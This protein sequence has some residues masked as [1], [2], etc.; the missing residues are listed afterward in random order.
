ML[1]NL[2]SFDLDASDLAWA[3]EHTLIVKKWN[4]D[5]SKSHA[6]QRYALELVQEN[7]I[8]I[9]ICCSHPH[10]LTNGRGL[11][12]ARKGEE[13]PDL[14]EF[15]AEDYPNLPFELFKIERG[16]GLTFHHPGQFI[17]YP[18]VKLNPE[19]LSLSQMTDEIFQISIDVLGTLGVQ[20]LHHSKKL[21]GLWCNHQKLASMGIA[22]EKLTTFHGMALNL[23]QDD[24]MKQAL[25]TLNPCGL[26]ASTYTSAQELHELPPNAREI[27]TNEFLTRILHAW[28]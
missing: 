26:S 17:F 18:I 3:N 7:P 13:K 27:F 6:F 19:R 1:N 23:F 16:G 11:Q 8:R 10:V 9:L 25:S 21:L 24:K 28:K 14:V 22:I 2:S 12:K 20:G 4:W 15:N 5:Y